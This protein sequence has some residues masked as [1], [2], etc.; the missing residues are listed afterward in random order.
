MKLYQ[1]DIASIFTFMCR[2]RDSHHDA[3]QFAS[4]FKTDMA[5]NYITTAFSGANGESCNLN[6]FRRQFTKLVPYF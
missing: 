2:R 3:T 6:V 4:V 5:S 1:F